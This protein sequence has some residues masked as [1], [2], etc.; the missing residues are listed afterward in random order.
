MPLTTAIVTPTTMAAATPAE[1]MPLPVTTTIVTPTTA[2]TVISSSTVTTGVPNG[3]AIIDIQPT[4]VDL[5]DDI[6]TDSIRPMSFGMT[7]PPMQ[8]ELPRPMNMAISRI[9]NPYEGEAAWQATHDFGYERW[10]MP[11]WATA[12]P[13]RTNA[14]NTASGAIP[15]RPQQPLQPLSLLGPTHTNVARQ[16][17]P[18]PGPT[19]TTMVTGTM[20]T[21]TLMPELMSEEEMDN[22][23][24]M[25]RR[26]HEL[27]RMRTSVRQ[28]EQELAMPAIRNEANA[29]ARY[30]NFGEIEHSIPPFSADDAYSVHKWVRDFEEAMCSVRP[31]EAN[32]M[33]FARRKLEGS[34]RLFARSVQARTWPELRDQLVAE[35]GRRITRLEV[36]KQLENRRRKPDESTHRYVLEM[37]EIASQSDI[38]EFELVRFII[39]GFND[40][41]SAAAA[42]CSATTMQQLKANLPNYE[43]Y[44]NQYAARATVAANRQPQP[45][46]RSG[47]NQPARAAENNGRGPR[48]YNCS[49]FGHMKPE[50]P[51][52][53]RDPESCFTCGKL[54]HVR[55]DCP[56]N[57]PSNQQGRAAAVNAVTDWNEAVEEDE[58]DDGQLA[59]HQRV[60]TAFIIDRDRR[61]WTDLFA[62]LDTGSP[63]SFVSKG[64]VA[65]GVVTGDLERSGF[66]GLGNTPLL[67]YG[68]ISA[69]IKIGKVEKLVTLI[70]LP[71]HVL[72][73]P[74]LLGRDAL[75]SLGIGLHLD[76]RFGC[77]SA[78]RKNKLNASRVL[79][80]AS[81][82]FEICSNVKYNFENKFDGPIEFNLESFY[83]SGF[84]NR[85]SRHCMAFEDNVLKK[86]ALSHSVVDVTSKLNETAGCFGVDA[87]VCVNRMLNDGEDGATV[88]AALE[89]DDIEP[90]I[91]DIEPDILGQNGID[92]GGYFG[93]EAAL[94]CLE[95][96]EEYE[97][98][99]GCVKRPPPLECHMTL[100]STVP[101]YQAPRRLSYYEKTEVDKMVDKLIA[102][103]IVR[104][105]DSTY[106]SPIVLVKK[107]TGDLR[108]CVDY[109]A[110]NKITNRD[111]YPLPLIDDCLDYLEG[112]KVFSMFDLKNGFHQVPM[113]EDSIRYT[114]FVTPRGQYEYLYMPFGLKNGPSIFQRFMTIAL[115][116]LIRAGL[117]IVYM[118]DIII[119]TVDVKTHLEVLSR[120]LKA[121][122]EY[123]LQLKLSKCRILQRT[124]DYLGY[125]VDENGIRPNGSHIRAVA[126]Y[127]MPKNVKQL[128]SCIGLFSYFRRFVPGFARKAGPLLGLMKQGVEY[129]F[130]RDCE[131]AFL[132]LQEAITSSPV[133]ALYRPGRETELHTDASADGFGSVLL[134]RQ[135]DGKLHPV[136]YYSRRTTAAEARY[137]S[138][139]LE[140]MAV[141]YSLRRFR[142]YLENMPFVIVTDCQS[143]TQ[144]LAKK[145]LNARIARWALELE[146]YNYQIRHRSGVNM[147]HADALSRI[148]KVALVTPD[149]V[150]MCLQ[151]AQSRDPEVKRIV[152][153][154]EQ[155]P[156]K[157]YDLRDGL[158]CRVLPPSRRVLYV[159]TEM[160]DNVIR[161]IHEKVGHL[162]VEKCYNQLR[163]HYWFP[164]MY[165]KVGDFIKNCVRCIMHTAPKRIN[166]R[167]LHS[168]P[169][170]PVPFHTLH[171]DHYGPLPSL[172][173]QKRY[174][175]VVVD[176]F[177]KYTKLYATKT[178]AV[179]E[180]I[181]SLQKY[182]SY[183]SRPVRVV[184]DMGSCFKH[185]NFEVFATRNN[186]QHIRNATA[187]PQA[188]GQVERV[189]RV[190]TPMLGKMTEPVSRSDWTTLLE[191]V[192]YAL[193]N[194]V[195]E[196]TKQTASRLLFGVDQKGPEVDELS[197]YL[198]GRLNTISRI[199]LEEIRNKAAE[200]IKISQN[201]NEVQYLK[202]SVPPTQYK[203]GDYVV[204][205]NVDT[206]IGKNKKLIPKYRGPYVVHRVLPNER[207]VIRDI[208]NCPV[209][210]MPYNG[211]LEAC[212]LKSWIKASKDV[213]AACF[214]R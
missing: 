142:V 191:R 167:I 51:K 38:D 165:E 146:E 168:I 59:A 160:E 72:P 29:S 58:D 99:S 137:H 8:Q 193:N 153:K 5:P 92:I 91:F 63:A 202:R 2:M 66:R 21:P 10:M 162:A 196:S 81:R 34:A 110:V 13:R 101:V 188:N 79:P 69:L 61:I 106:A 57:R 80:D 105:S 124:I 195:H 37:Q 107:K 41:S 181:P 141:V 42:I 94:K 11:D 200:D 184:S 163:F 87:G 194:T 154:L 132:T 62:L 12:Y 60:S 209:T 19:H 138:F 206:T 28:M 210:Q 96:L 114:A 90:T 118:D 119:G 201:R 192:E 103:G 93:K 83:A 214:G 18:L 117:I 144:T 39:N 131:V 68:K 6:Q 166:E 22:E 179:G 170:V 156:V 211:I 155:G 109:R 44:R 178:V 208:E 46:N 186:F 174:L 125:S 205:R 15:K 54:G 82:T 189:N 45:T 204:I 134:Q 76:P 25:L 55:R 140:T 40:R 70:V 159:P 121:L 135:E 9:A 108:M 3:D 27:L 98:A 32:Q 176:A 35:F 64:A 88:A 139:E 197:E 95:M 86:A 53:L 199:D 84:I 1:E 175:L 75:C 113:A 26:Q 148:P 17:L 65:A 73:S 183:Y 207:Y 157:N 31:D 16:P 212:R 48:C 100:T 50:C 14:G 30:V 123:G 149:E 20:P 112:K 71:D 102:Q 78:S 33:L 152:A 122:K 49:G 177:T 128:Q 89:A 180:V 133:L 129:K 147:G 158:L 130:D 56:K 173:N 182:F 85:I 36:Y 116:D 126:A 43:Y 150:D 164:K 172:K 67:T 74:L 190:L 52:P 111:N 161:M 187:A 104:P 127:P 171:V 23:M 143:L 185:E 115:G 47:L 198:D 145:S 120:L 4:I 151:I 24:R 169:K 77:K 97:S 203:E 213:V 7:Q 136:S